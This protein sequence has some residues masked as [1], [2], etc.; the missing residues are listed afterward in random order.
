MARERPLR[1]ASVLN[2]LA[3]CSGERTPARIARICECSLKFRLPGVS[4]IS[5]FAPFRKVATFFFPIG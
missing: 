3:S 1:P 2:A 5:P 4:A